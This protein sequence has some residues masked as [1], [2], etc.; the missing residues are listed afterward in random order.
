ML[1]AIVVVRLPALTF[2][3]PAAAQD[4]DEGLQVGNRGMRERARSSG[5]EL[6]QNI[7]R[8][9]FELAA[10]VRVDD[11]V[12]A[13]VEVSQ[14]ENNFEERLRRTKVAVK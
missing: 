6:H 13:A 2:G 8:Y 12:Q 9:L 11:G 10:I 5:A 1:A 14:P 7:S 4:P 3:L